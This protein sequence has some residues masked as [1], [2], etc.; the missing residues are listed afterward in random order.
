MRG[1]LLGLANGTICL[2]YCAP[3]IV[4]YFLG[5]GQTVRRNYLELGQFLTGRLIGYLLFAILAWS[6][7]LLLPE[8]NNYREMIFGASYILLAGVLVYYCFRKSKSLCAAEFLKGSLP[9]LLANNQ[10]L[11]PLSLGF[12][13][14]LNLCPPFLLAFTSA[15]S[16]GSLWSSLV[17][18][19]T[20]FLGTS[21]FFV[22]IPI[23]GVMK[24]TEVL[25]T[26][27]KMAAGVIGC[28]YFYMGIIIILGGIQ[29]L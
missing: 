3:V 25:Q 5:E 20:F 1:F 9:K 11:L 21:I 8:H 17:F 15:V 12:L 18:F 29:K 19:G 22:P 16:G 14:G 23:L 13:T 10:L 27:G 7:S 26:I 4:P 6:L 24:R 28:Y 2:A